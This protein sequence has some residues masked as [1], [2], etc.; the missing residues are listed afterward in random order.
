MTNFQKQA[1]LLQ[2]LADTGFFKD[3]V[4]GKKAQFKGIT[5]ED[6]K[7]GEHL[8]YLCNLQYRI[9]PEPKYR[10]FMPEEGVRLC[11]KGIKNIN[12][13]VD[14]YVTINSA[15]LKGIYCGSMNAYI[16][17]EQLLEGYKFKDG[18]RCGVLVQ[19]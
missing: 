19:E 13:F 15:D 8:K 3:V 17:Y 6:V 14:Y 12:S 9:K 5:W 16:Y 4:A 10:P 1:E 18:S 11:G 7:D 2:K